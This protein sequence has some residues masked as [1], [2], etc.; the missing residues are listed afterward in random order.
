MADTNQHKVLTGA[1]V[2]TTGLVLFA[3]TLLGANVV[4]T[5][6][7]DV[8]C[9]NVC[10]SH[11][12]ISPQ[13]QDVHVSDFSRELA[14][15]FDKQNVNWS[16]SLAND[17]SMTSDK[18]NELTIAKGDT[19][20]L[21]L[22]GYKE[23]TARVKWTLGLAGGELDPY[24]YYNG[25][26]PGSNYSVYIA[27][28][29]SEANFTC[30]QPYMNDSQPNGQN[31]KTPIFN[32][33]NVGNVSL[34]NIS[35]KINTTLNSTLKIYC[36]TANY[37]NPSNISINSSLQTIIRTLSVN[38]SKGIWCFAYCNNVSTNQTQSFNFSFGGGG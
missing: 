36:Q 37:V 20:H 19:L 34:T 18:I 30:Y 27:R 14:L 23:K 31:F 10:V 32:V 24:W 21:I 29:Y 4:I 26:T 9:D 13:T 16:L 15:S 38:Q 3:F 7:G 17:S 35:M 22:T 12:Y 8:A 5:S 28:N 33:T 2:V 1:A 6:N 25:T 11:I